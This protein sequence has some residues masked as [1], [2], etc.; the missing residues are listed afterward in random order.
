M[1]TQ[2]LKIL[3]VG[4]SS[5]GKTSLLNQA[6]TGSF[7]VDFR[8]TIGAQL[9]P[10]HL[11]N[12]SEMALD[13]WDTAGQEEYRTFIAEYFRGAHGCFIVFDVT[14]PESFEHLDSWL[15]YMKPKAE[16]CKYAAI[17]N[18]CDLD[19]PNKISPEAGNEWVERHNALF[20]WEVSA[21]TGQGIREIFEK[22]AESILQS[23]EDNVTDEPMDRP[24][25]QLGET[26]EKDQQS[27]KG[28]AC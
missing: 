28:C 4:D 23:Q 11:E 8:P 27:Q 14:R 12:G 18:K 15:E 25:V 21:K 7:T 22:M 2:R 13:V 10:V 9:L 6:T 19:D 24:G 20:Y 26:N 1:P 17:G 5:V 3:L 16:H